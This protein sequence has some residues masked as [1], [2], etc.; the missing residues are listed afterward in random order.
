[1]IRIVLAKDTRIARV[2]RKIWPRIGCGL[3]GNWQMENARVQNDVD[4][5][6]MFIGFRY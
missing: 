1:M 2:L 4:T 5:Y 3:L 6:V